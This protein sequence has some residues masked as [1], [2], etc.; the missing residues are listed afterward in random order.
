MRIG[1]LPRADSINSFK[2][3]SSCMVRL[4]EQ[5]QSNPG[6]EE[7]DPGRA[8]ARF[9]AWLIK[10]GQIRK[11]AIAEK[12]WNRIRDK[13]PEVSD[14]ELEEF[15]AM[16]GKERLCVVRSRGE[17]YLVL[18]KENGIKWAERWTMHYNVHRGHHSQ[19]IKGRI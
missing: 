9:L 8:G 3:D 13:E 18:T 11:L 19:H 7:P 1:Y 14:M 16:M 17:K 5:E 6:L 15:I 12:E 10:R 2:G 4:P